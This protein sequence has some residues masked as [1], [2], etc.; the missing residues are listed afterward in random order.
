MNAFLNSLKSDLLDRR[1]TPLLALLAAAFLGAV[2]YAAI[3]GSGSSTPTTPNVPVTSP[4]ATGIAVSAVQ[5][6]D[7]GP[8]AET[9]S[10]SSEQTGGASRNPFAPTPGVH[11]AAKS[12][13][14]S[15]ESGEAGSGSATTTTSGSEPSSSGGSEPSSPQTGGSQQQQEQP[16]AKKTQK[17][18]KVSVLFGTATPGTPALEAGLTSYDNLKRQQ[19][20][21][22]AK[23]P[24]V[25]FRGVVVGAKSATFTL[26]GEAIPRGEAVC[27][28]SPTQCQAI[29]LKVGQTEELEYVPLG[30]TPVN[31]ELQL[32]KIETVKASA[33]SAA[34]VATAA[35][36]GSAYG[37]ESQRGV[38]LLRR[39]G[40]TELPGLRYSRD[41][42]VLVFVASDHA[43]A[44]RAH[45]AAWGATARG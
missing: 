35:S 31:Y 14:A 19:P 28:P 17:T 21:P 13:A 4:S 15:G 2:V 25:V 40:L 26:V 36:A 45:A 1:V 27:K 24:V 12:T 8:A 33:A 32:V 7:K 9:T 30:G 18:Y 23:Q 42:S 39:E 11:T 10:G 37:G 38:K 16:P 3:G 34:S 6:D 5:S 41:G 43:L 29:D 20:L 44:A 22:S